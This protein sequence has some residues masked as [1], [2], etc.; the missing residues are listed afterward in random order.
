VKPNFDYLEIREFGIYGIVKGQEL[1]EVGKIE[2]NTFDP[3]SKSP[4]VEFVIDSTYSTR[5]LGG[6]SY[7]YLELEKT[8]NELTLVSSCCDAYDHHFERVR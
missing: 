2:L 6:F 8:K 1:V 7:K 4:Q 3:K 5:T